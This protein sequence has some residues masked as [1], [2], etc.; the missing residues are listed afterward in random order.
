MNRDQSNPP[1][2]AVWLLQH[3]Y[4][5]SHNQVLTGDLVEKFREGKSRGW[6]WKQVLI[7]F[8]VALLAGVR[9]RW[10]HFSYALAGAGIYAFRPKPFFILRGIVHWYALPWPWSQIVFE[11][12]PVALV[13]LAA[14]PILAATLAFNG[15]F[16]TVSTLRTGMLSLA[17]VTLVHYLPNAFPA[18]CRPMPGSSFVKVFMVPN[19]QVYLF[20]CAFLVSSWLGCSSPRHDMESEGQAS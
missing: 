3:A 5:K 11:W 19:G 8:A 4:P 20:F 2:L 1:K 9:R 7:A 17:L 12:T 13:A 14:L 18:V 6:F 15:A 10:P 16:R